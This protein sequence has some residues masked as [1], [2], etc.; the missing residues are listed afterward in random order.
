MNCL[1][2]LSTESP[3]SF[4]KHV[5]DSKD[6]LNLTWKE[7]CEMLN[8]ELDYSYSESWY[9]KNYQAGTFNEFVTND[10]HTDDYTYEEETSEIDEKLRKLQLKKVEVAD[11]VSSNNAMIR[12]MSREQTIRDIAHEFALV[13]S[14]SM[15]ISFSR[16]AATKMS[17]KEA[18]L[19]ISDWH[20]GMTCDNY[21]NKFDPDICKH[22]IT[23]LLNST[24]E[25]IKFNN[26]EKLTVL[27]LSDL[28][29]GRIHSQ[30]RIE[31]RFDV[32]TQTMEISEILAN[33]LNELSIYC[34]VDFYSCLD[35]HSR[36]EPNKKESLDLESLTR[37]IPWYLK[38]R[39][40]NNKNIKICENEFG[41]D[42]ITCTV[43]GH[44]IVAVHGHE[45]SPVNA[46]EKLSML[47]RKQYDL[48][49]M[50]HRHHMFLEEQFEGIVLSNGCLVGVDSHSKNMRLTS[51]PSQT[52]IIVTEDNVIEDIK[53]ILV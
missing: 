14:K 41:E 28:I 42:I 1:K 26:I 29:A 8:D 33:F 19:L 10:S 45:D 35:N 15:P 37:I 20:Y 4:I 5:C 30:I 27:D 18:I 53:R 48:V 16:A 12:R 9:R 34:P 50:A 49:C 21:W 13:M 36:V 39:L 23:K 46:L 2:K 17:D 31:S 44:S 40:L 51:K 7:L 24:I 3:I 43:K 25:A 11:M 52:L 22:R 6:E 32:I 47:T 38:E